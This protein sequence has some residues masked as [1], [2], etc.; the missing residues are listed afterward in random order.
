MN[1]IIFF[2]HISLIVTSIIYE[3]KDENIYPKFNI[4]IEETFNKSSLIK[5]KNKKD[6]NDKKTSED[7]INEM[8]FGWNLGN[9]LDAYK[10]VLNQG[11]KSETYW[12][13]PLT[14]EEIIKGLANK[15]I[16]TIRIPVTWHN[17][18]IDYNYTIDPEWMSRVKTVVDWSINQ[19]LY[20]ILNTHHDYYANY[21]NDTM[22]YGKGYYPLVKDKE[23]SEK[24][25]Y[26]IWK[27]ITEAFNNGYDHH[28]IFEP[29]NE[30]HLHGSEYAWKYIKGNKIC[31]EAVSTLNEYIQI[32]VKTIRES[33]GNNEKRFILICPLMTDYM[34]A[35]NS[36]FIFPSD[37]NYNPT[38]NKYILSV[39]SYSPSDFAGS[40]HPESTV[41]KEELYLENLVQ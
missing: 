6:F 16:K 35:I 39:H 37:K 26:N 21:T 17:H 36:D 38:N 13:N 8:G 14:T 5:D 3:D 24:F 20:V 18:L 41:Y 34:T 30:P 28:L 15:G 4:Q 23:E 31:E 40:N 1:Y 19:G 10:T 9:T 32:I 22:P 29:L 33:G 7:I 11:L 12:N 2:L 27:Q 25:I